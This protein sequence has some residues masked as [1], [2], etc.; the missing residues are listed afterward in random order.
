MIEAAGILFGNPCQQE[1][2]AIVGFDAA[3]VLS[4]FA[5]FHALRPLT[6]SSVELFKCFPREAW[7]LAREHEWTG[8]LTGHNRRLHSLALVNRNFVLS[9]APFPVVVQII[10]YFQTT[11]TGSPGEI[12][13]F[14]LG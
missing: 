11:T 12:C 4:G 8:I 1:D 13:T 6:S 9:S 2:V 14:L 10:F 7:L 3:L 5:C